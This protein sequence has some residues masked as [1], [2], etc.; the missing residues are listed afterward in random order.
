MK[1]KWIEV[2]A[3]NAEVLAAVIRGLVSEPGPTAEILAA[4]LR[5]PTVQSKLCAGI[6]R[7]QKK[8]PGRP[9]QVVAGP[10][11]KEPAKP[12]ERT[13][14]ADR[15]RAFVSTGAKTCPEIARHLQSEGVE[16]NE[17]LVGQHLYLLT[18][19]GDLL[20]DEERGVWRRKA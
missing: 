20:R 17:A 6:E 14:I 10:E 11:M 4:P 5:V 18:K 7:G 1:L 15:I 2:E 16:T 9:R 8:G 12:A 3:E 19:K 13:T